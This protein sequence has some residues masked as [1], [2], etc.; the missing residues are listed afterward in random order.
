MRSKLSACLITWRSKINKEKSHYALEESCDQYY[1]AKAKP[2]YVDSVM[3]IIRLH[4]KEANTTNK[5]SSVTCEGR[6]CIKCILGLAKSFNACKFCHMF[7]E[8]NNF[9]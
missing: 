8:E 6:D 2:K 5:L 3:A 9:L 4:W 7:H 1:G